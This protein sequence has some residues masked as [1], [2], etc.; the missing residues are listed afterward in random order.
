MSNARSHR[1]RGRR[2]GAPKVRAI[3]WVDPNEVAG[4]LDACACPAVIHTAAGALVV[5][6]FHRHGCPA[7]Q[8]RAS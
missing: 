8:D 7:L 5:E 3:A 4:R 2:H 1:R 6:H